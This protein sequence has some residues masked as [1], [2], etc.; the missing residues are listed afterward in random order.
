M[1]PSDLCRRASK[2]PPV[3]VAQ[4]VTGGED[5]ADVEAGV[6]FAELAAH[7]PADLAVR[8]VGAE[9]GI[10]VMKTVDD[11]LDDLLRHEGRL[12]HDAD[13]RAHDVL[14]PAQPADDRD[15]HPRPAWSSAAWSDWA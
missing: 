6:L 8:F 5:M 13:G 7:Q 3:T 15:A 12:D 9:P 4:V 2:A 11:F 10:D 1:R 14:D